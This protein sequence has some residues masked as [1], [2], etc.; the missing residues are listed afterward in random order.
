VGALALI[1]A[2]TAEAAQF[3]L[4]L[5]VW[6]AVLRTVVV[7]HV[8]WS[9]NSVTHVWGYR[10]YETS[11]RSRNNVLVAL[12]AAGEGWHNNHHA[13]P[14]SAR[15]GHAW[16]E[17]DVAWLF[18]RVLVL[19]GLAKNVATPSPQLATMFSREPRV[20]PAKAD[21]PAIPTA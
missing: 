8:T 21:T 16:W 3:G 4:S 5:L 2:G 14:T 15:H 9:V 1:G 20:A 11:D 12:V 19:L 6:G 18:I 17:L 7:W 10:R 13:D